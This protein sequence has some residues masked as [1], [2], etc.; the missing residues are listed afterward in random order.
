MAEESVAIHNGMQKLALSVHSN[1]TRSYPSRIRRFHHST[2]EGS[3]HNMTRESLSKAFDTSKIAHDTNYLMERKKFIEDLQRFDAEHHIDP[4]QLYPITY[5]RQRRLKKKQEP[6]KK[7]ISHRGSHFEHAEESKKTILVTEAPATDKPKAR[8]EER[9]N[10][11]KVEVEDPNNPKRMRNFKLKVYSRKNMF[12][13]FSFFQYEQYAIT[14]PTMQKVIIRDQLILLIDKA[15][16][17]KNE[18]YDD[19]LT[20]RIKLYIPSPELC[21]LNRKLEE[22]L[23]IMNELVKLLLFGIIET[24]P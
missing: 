15:G 11:P 9:F 21:Q 22:V 12:E 5:K 14:D 10:V 17:L 24:D 20:K 23:S 6:V 19:M 1:T 13:G 2:L 7:P 8:G 18:I 3:H 4:E 16:M